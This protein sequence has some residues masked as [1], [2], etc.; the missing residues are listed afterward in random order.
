MDNEIWIEFIRRHGIKITFEVMAG[1]S[2][3]FKG[4]LRLRR[5][6]MA[7][8]G[9]RPDEPA[10]V[11]KR[12]LWQAIIYEFDPTLE[13]FEKMYSSGPLTEFKEIYKE[14]RG[15][16][17]KLARVLGPELYEELK[18]ISLGDPDIYPNGLEEEHA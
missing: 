16:Y 7:F 13:G 5:K 6:S 3:Y 4:T 15:I 8:C 12:L 11:L 10:K 17:L 14:Y 18:K 2:G 9:H 1:E